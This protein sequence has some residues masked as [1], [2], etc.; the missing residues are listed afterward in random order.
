MI[1]N[2]KCNKFSSRSFSRSF[3]LPNN[4]DENNINAKI[5][6]RYTV[7]SYSKKMEVTVTKPKKII[8]MM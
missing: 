5:R 7:D 2:Y 6:Q 8:S 4:T 1:K 3:A